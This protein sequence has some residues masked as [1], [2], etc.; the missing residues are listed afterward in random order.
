MKG[1]LHY[2]ALNVKIE[3]EDGPHRLTWTPRL[4]LS[5]SKPGILIVSPGNIILGT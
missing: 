4:S 3:R 1:N 2:M 5:V